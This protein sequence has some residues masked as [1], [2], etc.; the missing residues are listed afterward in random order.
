M[1]EKTKQRRA[2]KKGIRGFGWILNAQHLL[3]L[4]VVF[5]YGIGAAI[6]AYQIQG[7]HVNLNQLEN[8]LSQNGWPMIFA[9]IFAFIPILCFRRKRFFTD[10][11]TARNKKI[12]VKVFLVSLFLVLGV[13]T[14]LGL[15]SYPTDALLHAIGFTA[16]PSEQVLDGSTTISMLVYTCL[17]APVLEEFLYRGFILRSLEKFGSF[18]AIVTSALLFGLM[19]EN[20]I[21]LPYAFGIGLIFG[22]LAK[23]YSIKLTI[24]IHIANNTLGELFSDLVPSSGLIG[25]SLNLV[26]SILP[27]A[28]AIWL[29]WH[30]RLAIR[31][32]F[33]ENRPNKA[34]FV[35][36]YTSIPI[37]I[38]IISNI[39]STMLGIEKL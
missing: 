13:N 33:R 19:H 28:V 14:V 10:D 4:L 39:I 17:I 22:Y 20:I 16:K 11:L 25:T 35:A 18:F 21:Q 9:V 15:L 34:A 27:V 12:T 6:A 26:C 3:L 29:I 23:T 38:L 36:F 32:W 30:Y 1:S 5:A 7:S 24:L 31:A 2:I 37:L 8:K